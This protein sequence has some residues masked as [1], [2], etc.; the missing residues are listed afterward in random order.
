MVQLLFDT[1]S[2]KCQKKKTNDIVAITVDVDREVGWT[3]MSFP[4][5][6]KVC[7]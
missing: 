7:P 3:V 5:S 6:N 2:V 4:R 1:V